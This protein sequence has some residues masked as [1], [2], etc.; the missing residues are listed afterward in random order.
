MSELRDAFLL[1][2]QLG[3]LLATIASA[4]KARATLLAAAALLADAERLLARAKRLS[5]NDR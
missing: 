5:A 2:F 3:V 4:A 1:I